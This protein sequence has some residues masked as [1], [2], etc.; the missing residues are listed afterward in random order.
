MG[1]L[2]PLEFW[3]KM[4][5][6]RFLQEVRD[7]DASIGLVL[8]STHFKFADFSLCP[9]MVEGA[10]ELSGVSFMILIPV[11]EGSTHLI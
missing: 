11:H 1:L 6:P 4:H 10:R 9:D 3:L 2:K 8:V 5:L 7:Q